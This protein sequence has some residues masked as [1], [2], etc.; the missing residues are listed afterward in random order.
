MIGAASTGVVGAGGKGESPSD[1]VDT[2]DVHPLNPNPSEPINVPKGNWV[3][4]YIGWVDHEG[5]GSEKED[6]ER[7]LDAVEMEVF[8]DGEEIENPD[9][10]WGDVNY[11]DEKEGYV[12]WWEYQSP[13]KPPGLYDY[14]VV[15]NY[16]D[17]FEDPGPKE[18]E[19]LDE[20]DN[21]LVIP[22]NTTKVLTSYYRVPKN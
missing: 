4:H 10:Y 1:K 6:V 21:E 7:W 15:Y 12:V 17:G 18:D 8:I 20:R 19:D 16:P 3:N 2:T 11:S 22:E 5:A 14:T 9:Q 13:P